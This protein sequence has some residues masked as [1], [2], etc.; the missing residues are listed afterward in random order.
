[1]GWSGFYF[2]LNAGGGIGNSRSDFSIAGNP[3]FASVN[4]YL[5]GASGG[6]QAGFNWQVGATVVGIETDIQASGLKGG[7]NTPCAA[8]LC[9]MPLTASYTQRMPW[10]GTVRGRLGFAASGWLIYATG[11]YAYARL[12]TDAFAAAGAAAATFSLH[13]T[14]NGW[15]VGSGIEVAFAPGWS[16]KLEYLY[17]DFGNRSTA[18]TFPALPMIVDDAHFTMN[19]VRAG[20]NYRF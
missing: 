14:R 17:L 5:P 6:A 11:G 12:E 20:V 10:F 8:G 13:E 2:G 1:M 18:M 3:A 9:G 7:I 16:A 15:T 4:N 19:V